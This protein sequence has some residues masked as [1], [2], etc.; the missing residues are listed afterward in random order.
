MAA[1]M[2]GAAGANESYSKGV[3]GALSSAGVGSG[4]MTVK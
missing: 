4:V 1:S 3:Q 2:M